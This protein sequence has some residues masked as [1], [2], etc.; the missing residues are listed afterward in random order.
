LGKEEIIMPKPTICPNGCK[1]PIF[2]AVQA[3]QG[4]DEA[5]YIIQCTKCGYPIGAI[6]YLFGIKGSIRNIEEKT[7]G[8]K[9]I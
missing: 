6:P 4:R 2:E 9:S 3:F 7:T 8:H 5:C 1:N